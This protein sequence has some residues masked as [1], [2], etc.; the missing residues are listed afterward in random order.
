MTEE[1]LV[2][3]V[4]EEVLVVQVTEEV[5]QKSQ[6]LPHRGMGQVTQEVA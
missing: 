1:V 3:E 5:V 2:V 4:T 6:Y